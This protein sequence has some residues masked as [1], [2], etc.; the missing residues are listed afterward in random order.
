MRAR[1]PLLRAPCAAFAAGL[2]HAGWP[3]CFCGGIE[4]AHDYDVVPARGPLRL[5]CVGEVRALG[6][7]CCL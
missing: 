6:A 2:P 1:L 7:V 3:M 5:S 4:E